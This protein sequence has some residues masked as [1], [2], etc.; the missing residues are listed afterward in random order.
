MQKVI[1]AN[2]VIRQAL[3]LGELQILIGQKHPMLHGLL[4]IQNYVINKVLNGTLKTTRQE[5]Y[6]K[7]LGLKPIQK[8][9]AI[10][11]TIAAPVNLQVV[12]IC[13]KIY[14]PNYLNCKKENVRAA[15]NHWA[16]TIT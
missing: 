3:L 5:N 15:S 4:Q 12:E 7:L 8:Q 9:D 1:D 16:T 11:T 6:L 13:L 10:T 14:P 2:H